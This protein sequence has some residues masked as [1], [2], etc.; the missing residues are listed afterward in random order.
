MIVGEAIS[1]FLSKLDEI[2]DDDDSGDS[3]L[4]EDAYIRREL[5]FAQSLPPSTGHLV[6]NALVLFSF[7]PTATYFSAEW[8]KQHTSSRFVLIN[9][10]LGY[11]VVMLATLADTLRLLDRITCGKH[12]FYQLTNRLNRIPADPGFAE[13]VRDWMPVWC[14][15]DMYVRLASS[16]DNMMEYPVLYSD[17]DLGSFQSAKP[18]V[19]KPAVHY[20]A[21][22]Y[23]APDE[24]DHR[25]ETPTQPTPATDIEQQAAPVTAEG[26]RKKVK[27]VLTP[28][29]KA[30]VKRIKEAAKGLLTGWK[31]FIDANGNLYY[32]NAQTGESSWTRPT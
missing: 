8:V 32:G 31:P 4:E 22:T 23:T 30:N 2:P 16:D 21:P 1:Q 10:G 5:E 11:N 7:G 6:Y 29:E 25:L 27:K 28:Q 9:I 15:N 19:F 18:L 17:Y 13:K 3:D 14:I 26:E 24:S 12:P 20:N